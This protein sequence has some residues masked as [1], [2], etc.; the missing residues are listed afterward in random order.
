MDVAQL[1]WLSGFIAMKISQNKIY[2]LAWMGLNFH[3]YRDYQN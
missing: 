3:D 2:R 1:V